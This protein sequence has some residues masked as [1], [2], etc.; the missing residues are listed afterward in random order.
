ME[1]RKLLSNGYIDIVLFPPCS[2]VTTPITYNKLLLLNSV[3]EIDGYLSIDGLNHTEISNLRFLRN[4]EVIHGYQTLQLFGV[5]EYALVVQNNPHLLTLSLASLRRIE[6]G[7]VR[8]TANPQLCLVD[9][10][11]VEDTLSTVD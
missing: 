3:H 10:I 7:G 2:D 8:V 6:N 11:A 4:L 9:T 1:T 5:Q